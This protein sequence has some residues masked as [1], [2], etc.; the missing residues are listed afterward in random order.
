MGP[1]EGGELDANVFLNRGIAGEEGKQEQEPVW[2]F[3]D[4]QGEEAV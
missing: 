4:Q 3:V 1:P 2:V